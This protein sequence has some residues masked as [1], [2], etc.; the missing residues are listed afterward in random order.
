MD[1]R[2]RV[3][4]G[5]KV[6]T[7]NDMPNQNASFLDNVTLEYRLD[8]TANKYVTLYYQ[9]NSYDW[10]DGYTQRYGAGFIWR[11]RLSSLADIFNFKADTP[12]LLTRPLA[13]PADSTS[14]KN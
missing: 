9:N 1:N 13:A 10:L 12:A 6:S 3:M 7:D 11:R 5:G 2:L 4:V 8:Q 14:Q